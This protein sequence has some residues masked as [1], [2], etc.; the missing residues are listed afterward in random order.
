MKSR[1]KILICFPLGTVEKRQEFEEAV[2]IAADVA[3]EESVGLIK[4]T[5]LSSSQD[6][7]IAIIEWTAE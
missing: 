2:G 5:W 1:V 6:N 7:L 4:V 3:K